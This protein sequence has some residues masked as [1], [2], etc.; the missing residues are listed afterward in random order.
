MSD[1]QTTKKNSFED[2]LEQLEA[3]VSAMESGEM[4]LEDMVQA[5]EKGQKLVKRCGDRLDEVE[6]RIEV[7]K[8]KSTGE[9]ATEALPPMA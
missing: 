5:F 6:R 7:I 2:D 1:D 4:G 3:L 8:R 9:V